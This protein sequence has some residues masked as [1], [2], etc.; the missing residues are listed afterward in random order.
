MSG[1]PYSVA[2]A[3]ATTTDPLH[4]ATLGSPASAATAR[5]MNSGLSELLKS[6]TPAPST[7]SVRTRPGYSETTVTP[8]DVSSCAMSDAM[9]SVATLASPHT[10]LPPYFLPAHDEKIG[11]AHV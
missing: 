3:A 5:P 7:P 9:R 6:K 11:R 4:L 1:N 8:C 10:V 2:S